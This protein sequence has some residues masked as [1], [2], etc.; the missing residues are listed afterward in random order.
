MRLNVIFVVGTSGS[1]RHQWLIGLK[2]QEFAA[3]LVG[4]GVQMAHVV[5]F[6]A[7]AHVAVRPHLLAEPLP[8]PLPQLG[9]GNNLAMG[10][11]LAHTLASAAH[12][13]VVVIH[14][15]FG[16]D[17]DLVPSVLEGTDNNITHLFAVTNNAEG[18][19]NRAFAANLNEQP[20]T[21]TFTPAAHGRRA[22]L[23]VVLDRLAEGWSTAA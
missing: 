15:L 23:D 5:Y 14:D 6:G 3:A 20:R 4:H 9:S 17:E 8:R 11:Q 13:L 22:S 12:T 1:L 10:L 16:V 2:Y 18:V 7:N 19:C 21:T